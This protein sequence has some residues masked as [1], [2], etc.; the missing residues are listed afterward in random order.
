MPC[1]EGESMDFV[2]EKGLEYPIHAAYRTSI[3]GGVA[4]GLRRYGNLHTERA[5]T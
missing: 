4:V 5:I 3:D 2:G 1:T